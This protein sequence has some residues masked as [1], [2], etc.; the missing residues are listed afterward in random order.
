MYTKLV[1]TYQGVVEWQHS[2]RSRAVV[3]TQ[4]LTVLFVRKSVRP[5]VCQSVVAIQ[6]L[7][8]SSDSNENKMNPGVANTL[9]SLTLGKDLERHVIIIIIMY[10]VNR[11]QAFS[12]RSPTPRHT[13]FHV[14]DPFILSH[15][16]T[17]H[18][19]SS[20]RPSMGMSVRGKCFNLINFS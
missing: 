15:T 4:L 9:T 7:S 6:K 1:L 2:L 8:K 18:I 5:S 14:H 11:Q 3:S 20:V 13:Q 12:A 16:A 19:H 10:T 17:K